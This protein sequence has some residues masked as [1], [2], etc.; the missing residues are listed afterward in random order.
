MNPIFRS[1]S[2][3]ELADMLALNNEFALETSFLSPASMQELIASSFYV[4]VAGKTEA[5]C[6]ALDQNA[7][8]EN[9]NFNWFLQK[10]RRFVYIDRVVVAA[11]ARGQGIARK[12]YS[13]LRMAANNARSHGALLRDQCRPAQCGF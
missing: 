3:D 4:R 7:Q 8:Y 12:M 11:Q 10:Y 13:D 6:I 2:V 1:P 9:T 5:F